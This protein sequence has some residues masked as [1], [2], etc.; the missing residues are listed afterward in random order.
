MV[1]GAAEAGEFV[2]A[3]STATKIYIIYTWLVTGF[4]QVEMIV[5]KRADPDFLQ[6]VYSIVE[7]HDT[8]MQMD[9][10]NAYHFGPK[11]LVELEVVM[12][13]APPGLF[14]LP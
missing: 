12:P 13:E 14:Q 6:K 9:Q 11:Y 8:R 7:G 5:G 3:T 1:Q 2:A 10:L 4:E